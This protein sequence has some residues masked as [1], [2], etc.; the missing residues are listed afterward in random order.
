MDLDLWELRY[1]DV[2]SDDL[3]K[4]NFLLFRQSGV[5]L[6]IVRFFLFILLLLDILIIPRSSLGFVSFLISGH[7]SC[8]ILFIIINLNVI[9]CSIIPTSHAWLLSTKL[10]VLRW[11][12]IWGIR[13][14]YYLLS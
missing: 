13:F 11:L 8:L 6:K 14:L 4:V 9:I 5:S 1:G 7:Y 3:V 12:L 2:R 10:H